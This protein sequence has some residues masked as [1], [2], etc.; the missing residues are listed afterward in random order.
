MPPSLG[1]LPNMEDIVLAWLQKACSVW[2][3]AN[4]MVYAERQA[5]CEGTESASLGRKWK[6]LGKG[7][8]ATMAKDY[9]PI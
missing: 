1:L 2:Q 3:K 8:E 5:R 7:R 9:L 4:L 6:A